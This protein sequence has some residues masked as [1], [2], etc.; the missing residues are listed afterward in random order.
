MYIELNRLS[1][2]ADIF[3]KFQFNTNATSSNNKIDSLA[4]K[5]NNGNVISSCGILCMHI[6]MRCQVKCHAS[7]T[8]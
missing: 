1:L 7:W 8:K 3:E 2:C 6:Y 4:T 5:Y